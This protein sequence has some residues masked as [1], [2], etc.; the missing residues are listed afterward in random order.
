[1]KATV[2]SKGQVTIPKAVRAALQLEPG[3]RLLFR[4]HSDRAVLAKL[5]DF[6]DLAGTVE[7]PPEV[8]GMSWDEIRRRAWTA[9][10][11]DRSDDAG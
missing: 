7:T 9:R 8:R 4:V 6:L 2:T 3:D 11:D 1:M 5:P 10:F